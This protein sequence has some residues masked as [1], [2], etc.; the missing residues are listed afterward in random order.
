MK[1]IFG[2]DY[3]GLIEALSAQSALG[4]FDISSITIKYNFSYYT[5][6]VEQYKNNNFNLKLSKTITHETSH[7][8]QTLTTPYGFYYKNLKKF[9]TQQVRTILY[10]LLHDYKIR[11]KYPVF[12]L[13]RLIDD[14]EIFSDLVRYFKVWFQ[15]EALSVY[16]DGHFS[17]LENRVLNN[18]FVKDIPFIIHFLEIDHYL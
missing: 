14:K 13:L 16:F 2:E 4:I 8:F 7:L 3:S 11:L 1:N 12:D 9:Q 10:K 15:A 17:S 6:F 5:E 18:P